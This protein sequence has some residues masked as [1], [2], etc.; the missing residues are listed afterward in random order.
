MKY[1]IA[2]LAWSL[3]AIPIAWTCRPKVGA[4][5]DFVSFPR[6]VI[7]GRSWGAFCLSWN[8]GTW[9]LLY[10][11]VAA[12]ELIVLFASRSRSSAHRWIVARSTTRT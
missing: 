4:S 1:V 7:F 8:V 2:C 10:A 9:T 6:G 5:F 11:G 3:A 12:I